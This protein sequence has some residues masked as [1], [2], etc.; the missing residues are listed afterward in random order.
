[1]CDTSANYASWRKMV[2]CGRIIYWTVG[3]N[4]EREVQYWTKKK[5]KL[6]DTGAQMET[7][8]IEYL[9]H[10]GLENEV[11][12]PRILS[13]YVMQ[14]VPSQSQ[15]LC[16]PNRRQL[17]DFGLVIYI[18]ETVDWLFLRISD[19]SSVNTSRSLQEENIRRKTANVSNDRSNIYKYN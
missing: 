15:G 18:F 1:M 9:R 8:P 10:F 16:F 19:I 3:K 2:P 12:N 4:F 6:H 11:Q 17:A 5:Q 14:W 7:N 13:T